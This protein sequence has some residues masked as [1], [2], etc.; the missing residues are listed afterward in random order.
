MV[1]TQQDDY[2]SQQ[3]RNEPIKHSDISTANLAAAMVAAFEDAGI[4]PDPDV[5]QLI[6]DAQ[7][8]KSLRSFQ[9]GIFQVHREAI[10][11]W[12]QKLVACAP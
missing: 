5:W 7:L 12:M 2:I 10:V 6:S 1:A 3:G 9:W 8:E 4:N 11:P